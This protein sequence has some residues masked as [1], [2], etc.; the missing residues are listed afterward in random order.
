MRVA[1]RAVIVLASTLLAVGCG[2]GGRK[3][4]VGRWLSV[5]DSYVSGEGLADGDEFCSRSPHAWVAAT[6]Q[7][8]GAQLGVRGFVNFTCRGAFIPQV[9]AQLDQGLATLRPG[10]RFDLVTLSVGGND[11]GFNEILF[12]CVGLDELAA[13]LVSTLLGRTP[14]GC[15]LASADLRRRTDLL[16]DRLGA[17]YDHILNDV[18]APDGT[19]VVFG[20]PAL[21]EPPERWA[22]GEGNHCDG[23]RRAD[24]LLLAEAADL[25]NRAVSG[26]AS[27]RQRVVMWPMGPE[28]VGHRRCTTGETWLYGIRLGIGSNR[29]SFHPNQAGHDALSQW[30]EARLRERY[31]GS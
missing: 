16:G 23:I 14:R 21:F 29:G 7:R 22:P 31:S 10:E 25:L 8:I 28:F 24:V 5:G 18:I 11:A 13:D 27:G 2:D 19:L 1:Q 17:L 15:D 3:A 9:E 26:A 12:D 4:P 20:Y 30:L 6:E